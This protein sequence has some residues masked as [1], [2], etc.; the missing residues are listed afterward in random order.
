[1]LISQACLMK[2]AYFAFELAH[3]LNMRPQYVLTPLKSLKIGR[4]LVTQS[5]FN[6]QLLLPNSGD[7]R[8]VLTKPKITE[9]HNF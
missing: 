2:P 8:F 9:K 4:P 1:M 7:R 5:K 3:S 6:S